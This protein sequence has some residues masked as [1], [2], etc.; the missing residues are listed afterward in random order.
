MKIKVSLIIA[1]LLLISFSH[2]AFGFET[3]DCSSNDFTKNESAIIDNKELSYSIT[4]V[5]GDCVSADLCSEITDVISLP[6]LNQSCF[7]STNLIV[8]DGCMDGATPEIEGVCSMNVLPTVWFHV[9]A[10]DDVGYLNTRVT[11]DGSWTPIWSIWTGS[12]C[13]NLQVLSS[14]ADPFESGISCNI[15]K[16][17][18]NVLGV[19]IQEGYS[20]YWIAVS[21]D[22]LVNNPSFT[23]SVQQLAECL[24]C[25]GDYGCEPASTSL[26]KILDRSSSKDLDDPGFLPGEVVRVQFEFIY[27]VPG[28][29]AEWLKGIIPDFGSGWDL[30]AMSPGDDFQLSPSEGGDWYL[31]DGSVCA[32]KI[33]EEMPFLCTYNDPI[34]GKLIVCNV[35]CETCPCA[36]PL[37]RGNA[38]PDGWYYVTD[39]EGHGCKNDCSPTS[40]YGYASEEVTT[41]T[42]EFTLKVKEYELAC[43]DNRNLQ[44]NFQTFSDGA[45][46]CWVDPYFPC[47]KD[48][49]QMGPKWFVECTC[50]ASIDNTPETCTLLKLYESTHGNQWINSAGWLEASKGLNNN[51][52]EW[53][54]VTCNQD[55]R[56]VSIELSGNNLVGSIPVNLEY[57][58]YLETMDVSSNQLVGTFPTQLLQLENLRHLDLSNNQ[59]ETSLIFSNVSS[60]KLE[61]LDLS[62]NRFGGSIPTGIADLTQLQLLN[63]SANNLAG[64]IPKELGQLKSLTEINLSNNQFEGKVLL[65]FGDLHSLLLLDLSSIIFQDAFRVHYYIYAIKLLSFYLI[66]LI[67]ITNHG[68]TYVNR[69]KVFAQLMFQIKPKET[70][71]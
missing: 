39:G 56:V 14:E 40:Q 53:Y 2:I 44:I 5:L 26:W 59:Y 37:V 36:A 7:E 12:D 48:F 11:T 54:G 22:G 1:F 55:G 29:S 23:L 10:T 46:G 57:L 61:S 70:M 17:N 47:N 64:E 65:E 13:N 20:D 6:A 4:H 15:E 21:A 16:S 38:L 9:S 25:M 30:S 32:P 35:N 62:Y 63:I 68:Q 67:F 71:P 43:Y 50:P 18:S 24:T 58:D 66:T 34:T 33:S 28:N 45:A 52:C 19:K 42:V 27:D 51:P 60:S 3:Y 41:F 8:V 31:Q 49:K 69:M